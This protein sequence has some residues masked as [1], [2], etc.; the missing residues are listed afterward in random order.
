MKKL[1]NSLK[2]LNNELHCVT[3]RIKEVSDYFNQLYCVSDK[4]NEVT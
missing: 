4:F 2:L 1:S 3:V